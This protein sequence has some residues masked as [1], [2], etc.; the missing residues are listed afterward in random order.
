VPSERKIAIETALPCEDVIALDA[1]SDVVSQADRLGA[2]NEG[3]LRALLDQRE[4]ATA[5]AEEVGAASLRQQP[6]KYRS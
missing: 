6:S 5:L 1:G 4:A 3:A 2:L